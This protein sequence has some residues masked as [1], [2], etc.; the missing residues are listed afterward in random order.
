MNKVLL[1]S[2]Y[3]NWCTPQDFFDELNQE[4]DFKLDAAAT[5]KS[6]KCNIYFTPEN[7]ALSQ[8]WDKGGS[9]FCNPPY[10]RNLK[11]MG[12]ESIR[13]KQERSKT[14]CF[15]DTSKNRYKL[16]P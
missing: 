1:S 15:A 8:S 9:V 12:T 5:E 16:F 10:G 2:K 14:Y 3:M 4:F 11:K 13:R 7:D 6:A